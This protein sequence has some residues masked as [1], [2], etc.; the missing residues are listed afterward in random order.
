MSRKRHNFEQVSGG[1]GEYSIDSRAKSNDVES[2]NGSQN[3]E[4]SKVSKK[5][6]SCTRSRNCNKPKTSVD[7]VKKMIT[8]K[9]RKK[10]LRCTSSRDC[11]EEKT[12]VEVVKEMITTPTTQ[13]VNNNR[14]VNMKTSSSQKKTSSTVR[15]KPLSFTSSQDCNVEKTSVEIVKG[16]ITTPTKEKY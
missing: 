2:L 13:E 3:K 11:N 12:S 14:G 10:L 7:V 9:L 5:R 1:I 16:V 4:S 15:N 8:K 6:F